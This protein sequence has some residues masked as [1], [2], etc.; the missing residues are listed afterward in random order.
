MSKKTLKDLYN[1]EDFF[2]Y[3][4]VPYHS[5]I[6]NLSRMHILKTFQNLLQKEGY[7]DADSSDKEVWNIQRALLF[8]AYHEFVKPTPARQKFFPTF[9]ERNGTFYAFDQISNK[10]VEKL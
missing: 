7:F 3:Y 2:D 8:R 10:G 4:H 1:A 6:L 5:E 9:Y